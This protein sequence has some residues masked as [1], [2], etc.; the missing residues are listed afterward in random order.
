M[1]LNWGSKL[2]VATYRIYISLNF[3]SLEVYIDKIISGLM[4][5]IKPYKKHILWALLALF[6]LINISAAFQAYQFTHFQEGIIKPGPVKDM[7]IGAKLKALLIGIPRPRPKSDTIPAHEFRTV[8]LQSN[9]KIACWHIKNDGAKGTVI[10][11]HGFGASKA[12]LLGRA[13][14][15][16]K[17]GY[18][19]F[20]VDFM[21]SGASEGNCTTIGYLE[22]E[23]VKTC[24]EYLQKAGERNIILFGNSMGAS[25]IL[26]AMNDYH[27]NPS[28][29]ILEVPFG[30]MYKT[31]CAR[32]KVM[33]VPPFPL[34]SLLVFWGGVE[35]GYWAFGYKPIEFAKEVKCPALLMWGEQDEYVRREETEGI[36]HN[37]AG[38]KVLK[39]FPE[40]RHEDYFNKYKA[41]WVRDICSFLSGQAD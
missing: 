22:A 38:R 13:D 17:M 9:V 15:F 41:E 24:Y 36:Y 21:G 29:I 8:V 14:E 3:Y 40:A 10:L 1:P 5:K 35:N 11:F 32:F 30:T 33:G 12:N 6:V 4:A 16:M 23:E 27:L 19:T 28:S 2:P 25:A 7:S 39:T 31:T 37:L 26:K 20:L 34:A 18:S